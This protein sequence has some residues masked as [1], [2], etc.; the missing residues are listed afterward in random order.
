MAGRNPLRRV[1][2]YALTAD[3]AAEERYLSS[4]LPTWASTSKSYGA[5]L[6]ANTT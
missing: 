1:T 3:T 6:A 5:R 4:P 2:D